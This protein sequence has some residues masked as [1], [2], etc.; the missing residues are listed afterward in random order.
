MN[1]TYRRS[2]QQHFS[3]HLD[4]GAMNGLRSTLDHLAADDSP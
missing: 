4:D 3:I 2:V 1:V